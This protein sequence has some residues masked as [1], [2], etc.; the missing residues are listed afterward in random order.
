MNYVCCMEHTLPDNGKKVNNVACYIRIKTFNKRETEEERKLFSMMLLATHSQIKTKRWVQTVVAMLVVGYHI[1]A[2]S[3]KRGSIH[4]QSTQVHKT[5][6][7]RNAI[8]WLQ[9]KRLH[10]FPH[11]SFLSGRPAGQL[12]FCFVVYPLVHCYPFFLLSSVCKFNHLYL[13][14]SN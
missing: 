9:A 1:K 3:R 4:K 2:F 14:W 6:S 12:H 7:P 8:G 13:V 10:V 11:H 5:P